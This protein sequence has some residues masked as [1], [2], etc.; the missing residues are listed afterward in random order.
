MEYLKKPFHHMV[1][2]KLVET[3]FCSFF[4]ILV[5]HT[6]SLRQ[7][8]SFSLYTGWFIGNNH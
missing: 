1:T 3:V 2:K 7:T 8:M 4:F 5:N 6:S